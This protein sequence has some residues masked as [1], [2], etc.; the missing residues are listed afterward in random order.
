MKKINKKGF[1][2]IELLAVIVILGVLM[3]IAIPAVTRYIDS[4]KFKT[5][6][7]NAISMLD[8]AVNEV[9]YSESNGKAIVSGCYIGINQGVSAKNLKL[10]KDIPSTYSGFIEVTINS[11]GTKKYEL[12]LR[13]SGKYDISK[14]ISSAIQ[15]VD[16]A[17]NGKAITTTSSTTSIAPTVDPVPWCDLAN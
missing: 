9:V 17:G 1:T 11:D 14:Q 6:K 8:A 16:V 10:E 7:S 15:G 5:F 12:T 13:E 2:L 4:S 3:L